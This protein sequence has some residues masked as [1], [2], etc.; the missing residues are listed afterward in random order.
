M[1]VGAT[2]ADATRIGLL[3]EGVDLVVGFRQNRLQ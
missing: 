1:G 2:G 3:D